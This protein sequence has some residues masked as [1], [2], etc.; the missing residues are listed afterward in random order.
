MLEPF[1]RPRV[2]Q[3]FHA[4]LAIIAIGFAFS[5]LP[6]ATPAGDYPPFVIMPIVSL[7]FA[8]RL[9]G[10]TA[11]VTRGAKE[12]PWAYRVA[13]WLVLATLFGMVGALG[14]VRGAGTLGTFV[15]LDA[16]AHVS[17]LR[18]R[19]RDEER[20][21]RWAAWARA[22]AWILAAAWLLGL[23]AVH[24]LFSQTV[25]YGPLVDWTY[26]AIGFALFL[27]FVVPG[28]RA[29]EGA[30]HPP[31]AHRKHVAQAKALDDPL[32][33]GVAEACRTFLSEGEVGPLLAT[34]REAAAHAA[35]SPQ[36]SVALETEVVAALAR[37]GTSREDDLEAAVEVVERAL[38]PPAGVG[39][40]IS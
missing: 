17:K 30:A 15:A 3:A 25:S 31:L 29:P 19:E 21:S 6:V 5:D 24:F 26:V 2:G 37:A 13:S 34:V 27:R 23:G 20:A 16:V 35:L 39:G 10:I 12:M 1:L 7:F 28:G 18:P 38:K 32:A 40:S 33:G 9:A 4:I 11:G 22:K 14:N 8:T 36:E